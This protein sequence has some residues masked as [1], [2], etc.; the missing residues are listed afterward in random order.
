MTRN[1]V[2][3]L[4]FK[5]YSIFTKNYKKT[6]IVNFDHFDGVLVIKVNYPSNI[7]V[8]MIYAEIIIKQTQDTL[9]GVHKSF[10]DSIRI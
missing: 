5:L 10:S 2:H 3:K 7:A 8:L 1:G 6:K 9:I 4:L